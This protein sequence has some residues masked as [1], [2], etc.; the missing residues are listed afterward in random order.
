MRDQCL[1]SSVDGSLSKPFY[2]E[3]CLVSRTPSLPELR[4]VRH[5][6]GGRRRCLE[7]VMFDGRAFRFVARAFRFGGCVFGFWDAHLGLA[8]ARLGLA[9]V[10][11]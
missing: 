11:L 5:F 9:H 6:I 10:S 7:S 2:N 3:D 4:Q 8:Y 1:A